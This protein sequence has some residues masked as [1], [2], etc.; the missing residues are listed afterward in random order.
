[1]V[2]IVTFCK[3]ITDLGIREEQNGVAIEDNENG[4]FIIALDK[5]DTRKKYKISTPMEPEIE[6]VT[7][8]WK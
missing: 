5:I 1:M 3:N 2:N 6:E 4:I 7:P 8:E